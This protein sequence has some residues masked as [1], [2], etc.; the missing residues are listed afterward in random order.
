MSY[1]PFE[2]FQHFNNAFSG[3]SANLENLNQAQQKNVEAASKVAQKFAEN[4]QS[5]A[6]QY[7]DFTQKQAES[8]LKLV[9]DLVSNANN[10]EAALSHMGL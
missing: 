9:K 2:A 5:F 1:N 3:Q 8:G 7:A 10:P 4:A 6:R